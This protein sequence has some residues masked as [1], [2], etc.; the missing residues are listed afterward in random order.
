MDHQWRAFS[1]EVWAL[2][3]VLPSRHT[4]FE[5]QGGES[6]VDNDG[7]E[8][9]KTAS[10]KGVGTNSRRS[11]SIITSGGDGGECAD[12]TLLGVLCAS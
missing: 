1:N 7:V 6:S 8:A 10:A 11:S 12:S 2:R 4:Y 5:Q 3:I 9:P